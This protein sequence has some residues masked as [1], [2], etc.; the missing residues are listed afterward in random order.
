M[1]ALSFHACVALATLALISLSIS[2]A[3]FAQ[4]VEDPRRIADQ[5]LH[6]LIAGLQSDDHAERSRS[7]L[8][9]RRLGPEAAEAVPALVAALD[10]WDSPNRAHAIKALGGI[11]P[12]GVPALL[13]ILPGDSEYDRS[14]AA[15]ALREVHTCSEQSREALIAA[16]AHPSDFVR[17]LAAIAHWR[18]TGDS[19]LALPV[20]HQEMAN[21]DNPAANYIVFALMEF[22]TESVLRVKQP[23]SSIANW[24]RERQT[25][26]VATNALNALL[27]ARPETV[28]EPF[29]DSGIEGGFEVHRCNGVPP[30]P[31]GEFPN[32]A[33]P[34]EFRLQ[35][36]E[37]RSPVKGMHAME[38]PFAAPAE[39]PVGASHMF[40]ISNAGIPF[41]SSLDRWWRNDPNSGW[42]YNVVARREEFGL[43]EHHGY[44]HADGAY[45]YH[46]QPRWVRKLDDRFGGMG[47]VG[48]SAD[49]FFIFNGM[50]HEDP[51]DRGSRV[52]KLRSSYQLK[53]GNRPEPPLGPG[54]PHDGTFIEDYEYVAGSGDLDRCNGREGVHRRFLVDGKLSYNYHITEDFPY[55]PLYFHSQPD[56]SFR[57]PGE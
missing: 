7:A 33:C 42:R 41:D 8:A 1:N 32:H 26:R 17:P 31:I 39:I 30:H 37:F 23:L 47:L 35:A 43:D 14:F 29:D 53:K 45:R 11:G 49:G 50:G 28:F 10:D 21:R 24:N 9:L 34:S 40:G 13:A 36:Y 55:V 44:I 22:D 46:G 16:L 48:I 12:A 57:R 51:H 2:P 5:G 18:A 6:E 52:R 4:H 15:L 3:S 56:E 25:R 54:G 27:A 20:L 19:S 38:A